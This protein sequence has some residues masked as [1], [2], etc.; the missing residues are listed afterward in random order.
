MK[1]KLLIIILL[2]PF[3]V[4]AKKSVTVKIEKLEK[5]TQALPEIYTPDIFRK[6]VI[7]DILGIVPSK[8]NAIQSGIVAQSHA[9]DHLVNLGYHAFFDGM[10][11]AYAGHR[12]VVLSPDIIWLL[13]AQGFAH[14]VNNNAEELRPLF[15]DF[16]GKR[17]LEV[18]RKAVGI[19]NIKWEK[20]FPEF[21]EQMSEY[22]GKE[23]MDALSCNFSTTTSISKMA[24]EIT[25]MKAMESYFDFAVRDFICGIP[26]VRLEGKTQDWEKVLKKAQYL[27]KYQL[28]WWIDELEPILTEFIKTSQKKIDKDF[29]R[30][31]LIV[32]PAGQECI[33]V[34]EKTDGWIVK[35]FP[36]DKK[37]KRLELKEILNNSLPN[38]IVKVDL[39]YI[40]EYDDGSTETEQLELWAGFIG[41]KQNTETYL[42]EPQIGWM[43]RNKYS[44][45][46]NE[47]FRI[48]D[49]SNQVGIAMGTHPVVLSVKTVPEELLKLQKIKS[50]T[51]RF[52]DE[53]IIPDEMANINIER[54]YVTGK[55]TKEETDRIR[56][57]F[58]KT[59]LYINDKRFNV[60]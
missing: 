36:Y 53:I 59:E 25:T 9:E 17:S 22:A 41:L 34:P 46:Q 58:P 52:S 55:I 45:T 26:E 49:K 56:I 47:I 57:M 44:D 21:T 20:V 42:L 39:D 10:R 8:D 27:K 2:S 6:L 16:T 31:M 40:K 32:H 30:N 1:T 29:W 48:S 23:L 19:K 13:I 11:A 50:L 12:P 35:F 38:E 37:G 28:G 14:H 51:I 15:V 5:P 7:S 43:I 18:K 54:M 24:S 3:F 33:G 4:F 60:P